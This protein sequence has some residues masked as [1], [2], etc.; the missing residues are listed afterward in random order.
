MPALTW[1]RLH[2]CSKSWLLLSSSSSSSSFI[3][4]SGSLTI[5]LSFLQLEIQNFVKR[6]IMLHAH[7]MFLATGLATKLQQML[8]RVVRTF[9]WSGSVTIDRYQSWLSKIYSFTSISFYCNSKGKLINLSSYRDSDLN[10]N[11]H[12]SRNRNIKKREKRRRTVPAA[13][14]C[15]VAWRMKTRT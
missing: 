5:L 10:T 9:Y 4:W 12:V 11:R 15:P 7:S 14:N 13:W 2:S 3:I 6:E 1:T 8:H